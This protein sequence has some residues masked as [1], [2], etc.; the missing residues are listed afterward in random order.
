MTMSKPTL[1]FKGLVCPRCEADDTMT[2]CLEGLDTLVCTNC[3]DETAIDV[4]RSRAAAYSGFLA[5][6]DRAV[7]RPV[8]IEP[9]PRIAGHPSG[10]PGA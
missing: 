7:S 4:I 5:W 1:G 3:Q 8:A 6:L 9:M 2:L 10:D